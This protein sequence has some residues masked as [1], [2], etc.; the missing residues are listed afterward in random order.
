MGFPGLLA[1]FLIT[2]TRRGIPF[3]EARRACPDVVYRDRAVFNRSFT[4]ISADE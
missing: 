2:G 3:G 4:L 1:E